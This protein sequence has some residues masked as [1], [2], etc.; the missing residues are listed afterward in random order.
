MP[1][2]QPPRP[3][4]DALE[5]FQTAREEA[6]T[7]LVAQIIAELGGG[8]AERLA[9]SQRES[10]RLSERAAA[11]FDTD[12]ELVVVCALLEEVL[13]VRAEEERFEAR[14]R[15]LGD[16]LAHEFPQPGHALLRAAWDSQEESGEVQVTRMMTT[17]E[18]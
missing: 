15:A 8:K 13:A 1:P 7:A 9:E 6:R 16:I 4:L 14:I 11:G 5:E 12:E 10:Q 17:L 3:L 2:D 18:S